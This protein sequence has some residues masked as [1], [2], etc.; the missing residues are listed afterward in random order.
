LCISQTVPFTPNF[1][2][3]KR[4][5]IPICLVF[6]AYQCPAQSALP[7]ADSLTAALRAHPRE[8]S[9]HV[10]LL[11][12]LTRSV[13]YNSPDSAMKY[14]DEV[15]RISGR[16]GLRSGIA[17]GY[18]YKG[19]VYYLNGDYV[20]AL[21]YLQRALKAAESLDSKKF[22]ASMFNNLAIVY[23]ELKQYE[24]AL[25]YYQKYL[26]A[27]R[28]LGLPEEEAKALLNIG[29]LYGETGDVDKGLIYCNQSLSL[30]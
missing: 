11:I 4:L 13:I 12:D 5:V 24:K 29:N 2:V 21:D 18:R 15:L 27:S 9:I 7:K 17:F 20:Q 8:D 22:D 1:P 25:S 28:E 6:A 23:M 19:L 26:S 10:Q 14:S 16:I 3:M 30:G